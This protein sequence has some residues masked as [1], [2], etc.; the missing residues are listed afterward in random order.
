MSLVFGLFRKASYA[1]TSKFFRVA[2]LTSSA[3]LSL[4]HG[5]ND[6]QKTMGLIVA[7]LVATKAS[8]AEP[9][10]FVVVHLY[11]AGHE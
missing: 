9:N 10:G 1:G 3:L 5:G 8:F 2:Q 4:A 6:A 11:V 7:L